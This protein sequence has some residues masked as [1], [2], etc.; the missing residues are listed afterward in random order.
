[1]NFIIGFRSGISN[2]N[3]PSIRIETVDLEKPQTKAEKNE[4]EAIVN[5]LNN[6]LQIEP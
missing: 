4:I 5:D 3:K 6:N 1:M 2:P